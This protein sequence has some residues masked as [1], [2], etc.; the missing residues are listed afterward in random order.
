MVKAIKIG[1]KGFHHVMCRSCESE[2]LFHER[3]VKERKWGTS[4]IVTHE[5]DC[6]ICGASINIKVEDKKV[7]VE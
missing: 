4:C 6:P 7:I 3:D 5:I 2:L 1:T